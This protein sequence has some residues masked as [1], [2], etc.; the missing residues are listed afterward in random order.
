M[1]T[2]KNNIKDDQSRI[3]TPLEAKKA[4]SDYIVMGRPITASNDPVSIYKKSLDE[5]LD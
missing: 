4:G 1:T 5:F 2:F 3:M